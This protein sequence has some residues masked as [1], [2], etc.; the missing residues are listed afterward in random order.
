MSPFKWAGASVQ[1][2]TVSR[3]VR[4]SG[5]YA[6]YTMFRGSVKTTGYPLHSPVFP[7]LPLPCVTV[8]H[9][10]STGLFRYLSTVTQSN[11]FRRISGH[12]A[13]KN[14]GGMCTKYRVKNFSRYN[15]RGGP[16]KLFFFFFLPGFEP[17]LG[18]PAYLPLS[19]TKSNLFNY[20][21]VVLHFD[22]YISA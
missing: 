2:T 16:K 7:S 11:P 20:C 9:L 8:C 5:S 10:I 17:T 19:H 22:I 14:Q 3:G 18:D 21:S 15:P 6:G 1:S 13:A 12:P 4:I